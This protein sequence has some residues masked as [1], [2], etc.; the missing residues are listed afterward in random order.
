MDVIVRERVSPGSVEQNSSVSAPQVRGIVA[1]S[2]YKEQGTIAT[3]AAA[4]TLLRA[5]AENEDQDLVAAV[6]AGDDGAFE[7]LY[8]RYQRRIS[9]YVFGM[10]HDHGRAEDVT[11]EVFI[12]ALRRLRAND[13]PIIF[14]P[15]V[16]EIAKNAC[17]DAF[18]RSK[19]AEEVSYDADENGLDRN[20]LV[21][22]TPGP[23]AAV[24]QRMT[25][26]NL[27]GAFG[28]LSEAHHQILVMR[29]LEG[30]SYRQIGE[31]L[32][33]SRPSVESTLF[34]ARRRLTEEY[35]ELVSGE[36]CRRVQGIIEAGGDRRLGVRDGRKMAR[37]VS[38][39]QP[40]RR[41][42]CLAGLDV[43]R[44]A[45]R[46]VRERI[47]AFLP[48]PDFLRRRLGGSSESSAV[49]VGHTAGV[50]Q[51]TSAVAAYSDPV[52]TGWAR[53]AAVAAGVAVAGLGAG[54]AT[55]DTRLG[56]TARDAA[57]TSAVHAAPAAATPVAAGAR[58]ARALTLRLN[59]PA[60]ASPATSTRRTPSR[61]AGTSAPGGS[62]PSHTGATQAPAADGVK[63]S[64]PAP[65]PAAGGP[66]RRNVPVD[67]TSAP[68][69]SVP[70]FTA[71]S[72][73]VPAST[74][75]PSAPSPTATVSAPAAVNDAASAATDAASVAGDTVGGVTSD[76]G[77][78]LGGG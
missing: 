13:A 42:A 74:S 34:R 52:M 21:S 28:G 38:H 15:W 10:V 22:S 78:L 36:R 17:I 67:T 65:A 46:P 30:L 37:H 60:T 48:L 47:A 58:S 35:A 24:D 51:L 73:Q 63:A 72:V 23:D 16:Y 6:R 5:G 69:P 4:P 8:E 64:A 77:N 39:C 41:A 32:G 9:A 25:L 14:K 70:S 75:A 40:C 19:R 1:A 44:L 76:A 45:P 7:Q 50:A 29:E 20:H 33:M 27:Q 53:A 49:A 31:R 55:H 18:R 61:D 68:R 62:A 59:G 11:Q 12:S 43:D 3:L 57:A 66:D 26:Q 56:L 2:P 71:P 54:V